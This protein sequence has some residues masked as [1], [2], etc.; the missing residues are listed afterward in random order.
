[1]HTDKLHHKHKLHPS[2]SLHGTF[3]GVSM[4]VR[5]DMC[6]MGELQEISLCQDSTALR[7]DQGSLKPEG[8]D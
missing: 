5:M 8:L 2:L 7:S 6:G 3:G 1:M 4:D